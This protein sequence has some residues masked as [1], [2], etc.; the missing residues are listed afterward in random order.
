M[1]A[2]AGLEPAS[3]NGREIFLPLQFS[4]PPKCLWSGL[5]LHLQHYLLRASRQVS[6]RSL[7]GFARDCHFKGFPEFDR[8]H[9]WDFSQ[10]AQIICKSP[11]YTNSTNQP[12]LK[13]N[14]FPLHCQGFFL[15]LFC[16]ETV[17]APHRSISSS[18]RKNRF[19]PSMQRTV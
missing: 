15:C 5:S 9:T 7:S 16:Q 19:I 11:V 13:Y 17:K 6:T 14:K 12:C 4:L 10:G 1:V 2:D 18:P 8:I 3:P